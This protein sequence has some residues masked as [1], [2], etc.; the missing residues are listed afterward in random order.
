MIYI[1]INHRYYYDKNILAKIPGKRYAYKFDFQALT[2][3]CRAQQTPTP[4]DAK[5]Q[6]LYQHLAPLLGNLESGTKP[7][8]KHK[9]DAQPKSRWYEGSKGTH[10][11][12]SSSSVAS[13]QSLGS[14]NETCQGS[15]Q[16]IP[17][18]IK[19]TEKSHITANLNVPPTFSAI[20]T[21]SSSISKMLPIIATSTL[22]TSSGEPSLQSNLSSPH[23][24]LVL[25]SLASSSYSSSSFYL[26]SSSQPSTTP[27]S[28][29]SGYILPDAAEEAIQESITQV[30]RSESLQPPSYETSISQIQQ[31]NRQTVFSQDTQSSARSFTSGQYPQQL[32]SMTADEVGIY[33]YMYVCIN[34]IFYFHQ[35]RLIN[36]PFLYL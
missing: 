1:S 27:F 4:S 6:E 20:S 15:P 19:N 25:S 34:Q 21:P 32:P 12:P 22:T 18:L 26:S 11:S 9:K 8:L 29:D 2:V 30:S 31:H 24:S 14:P 36:Y 35:I 33:I 23:S 5:P 7:E 3:A 13:I 28:T 10:N 17:P 16:N